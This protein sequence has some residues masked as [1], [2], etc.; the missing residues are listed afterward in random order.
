[1]YVVD[2]KQPYSHF[3]QSIF[4][5]KADFWEIAPLLAKSSAIGTQF[6]PTSL[7][8]VLYVCKSQIYSHFVQ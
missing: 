5:H 3:V 6:F 4:K 1:M 7:W 8:Q 2:V